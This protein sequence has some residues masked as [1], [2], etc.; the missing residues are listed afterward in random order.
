MGDLDIF[1]D[2]DARGHVAP[3][4]NFVD[5]RAQNRAQNAVD[6]G[7]APPFREMRLDLA[8]DLRLS[9]G[10]AR[11]DVA[12]KALVSPGITLFRSKTVRDEFVENHA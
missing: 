12:E 3:L 1:I 11:G 7:K 2:D 10:N 9:M 6:A 4:Q 5:A 8:I